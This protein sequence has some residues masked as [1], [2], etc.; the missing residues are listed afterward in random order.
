MFHTAVDVGKK[1]K[2]GIMLYFIETCISVI[3][4][5]GVIIAYH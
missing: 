3:S 2:M 5:V 1:S 4:N